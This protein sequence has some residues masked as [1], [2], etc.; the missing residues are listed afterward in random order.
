LRSRAAAASDASHAGLG[1]LLRLR[2]LLRRGL[3]RLLGEPGARTTPNHDQHKGHNG[4]QTQRL[5]NLHR[6]AVYRTARIERPFAIATIRRV[7]G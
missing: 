7:I 3:L 4:A 1:R 2:G 6:V 5:G